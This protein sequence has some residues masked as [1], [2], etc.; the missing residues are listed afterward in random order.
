M[1][2]PLDMT[3]LR[4]LA[5]TVAHAAYL[6]PLPFR[7]ATRP[8]VG[9]HPIPH[10]QLNQR[11]AP[12]LVAT[13]QTA[14]DAA[15]MENASRVGYAL[16][17]FEKHTQ[18]ITSLSNGGDPIA[19]TSHG[20]IAHIHN[21]DGSMHM[22]LSPADAVVAVEA[23]WAELHGLAGRAVGLPATYLMIYAPQSGQDVVIVSRLLAAAI[24][25]RTGGLTASS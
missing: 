20:E 16:S 7:C 23:G 6:A 3:T 5:K 14:F 25:Y 2:D 21:S 22:I 10:R 12:H 17:H 9:H 1:R 15:V 4:H 19:D 11:A 24:A 13:L 18:A 8:Q